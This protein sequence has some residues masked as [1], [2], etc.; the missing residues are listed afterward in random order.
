LYFLLIFFAL[1]ICFSTVF[2]VDLFF[3]D[4]SI[5]KMLRKNIENKNNSKCIKKA[6]KSKVMGKSFNNSGFQF[7]S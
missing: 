2:N 4:I 6:A 3:K 5:D 7:L 1:L